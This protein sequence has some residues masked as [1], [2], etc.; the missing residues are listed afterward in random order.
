MVGMC[1]A[2]LGPDDLPSSAESI[3]KGTGNAPQVLEVAPKPPSDIEYLQ[4]LIAIQQN[5]PKNIGFFGTRNMGFLHQQL[6]EILSYAMVL[7]DNH[8]FTSGATGTNAAVIRG[9]LRAERPDLLTVVLPQSLDKQPSESQ[10]LLKQVQET[11]A[12]LV[13]MPDN[14]DLTLFEA[15]SI[16]N[17]DII[18][19]VQQII[20]FAF[21]DSKLLLETCA[22]A[23]ENKKMVTLFYLD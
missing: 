12:K 22:Q 11:G 16:C 5:G 4:E 13:E 20:C 3:V 10:E 7:T 6:I 23:K 19:R 14:D 17:D 15:S 8:I 9:A 18:S 1:F 2:G 21:H